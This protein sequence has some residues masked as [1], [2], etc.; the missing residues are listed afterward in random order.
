MAHR[1]AL[2]RLAQRGAGLRTQA[3]RLSNRVAE[4]ALVRIVLMASAR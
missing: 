4:L 2:R 3:R 1:A